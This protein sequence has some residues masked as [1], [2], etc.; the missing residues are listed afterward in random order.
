MIEINIEKE[1][2]KIVAIEACGHSGYAEAGK[3]IVCSAV[4]TLTQTLINGLIEVVG[5]NVSYEIDEKKP[6]LSVR[7]PKKLSADKMKESQILML[8][9][10][11]GLKNVLIGHEKFIK[12]KEKQND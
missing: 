2:D 7:L 9:T 6:Y 4:S 8:S 1:K 11:L 5:I 3:D 10:Y 12:I